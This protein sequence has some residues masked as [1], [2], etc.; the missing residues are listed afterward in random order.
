MR[1]STGKYI[2]ELSKFLAKAGNIS[3][4][5]HTNP[6]GD[7]IGSVLAMSH[8]L[9]SKNKI[10]NIIAPSALPD[11]LSWMQG[12]DD[13]CIYSKNKE[14]AR[15]YLRGADLLLMLDFNSPSRLG[16]MQEEL[17]DLSCNKI[18]IDH[19]PGPD[20]DADMI[21][22]EPK[23]C[24]T[25]ELVYD[26]VSH[27]DNRQYKD[28]NFVEAVYVGMMTDTGNFSFGSYDGDTMRIVGSLLENGLPKDYITDKVYNNFSADRM[29][30][31]GFTLAERMII[32][33]ELNTAY[34]YLS[35]DDL[36]RFNYAVGDT[37][38][39]VN[40]PLSIKGIRLSVMF[41]EKKDHVK[42]SLRSKGNFSV[43]DLAREFFNGGG[44]INA[45]GG[46]LDMSMEDSINYFKSVLAKKETDLK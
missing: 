3:L 23:F 9:R 42:L 28:K 30:L 4:I 7:A 10:C 43:N 2:K 5:C 16:N 34:I 19:H 22:S 35:R 45:S 8:Y 17:I 15:E 20:V 29:R 14:L 18:L 24:S 21:I 12:A 13:I 38:G 31:K 36:D 41:I 44:H 6:D 27:L 11:F 40:M 25:A 46:R 39:F 1:Q 33:E 37:E 32:I 26:L